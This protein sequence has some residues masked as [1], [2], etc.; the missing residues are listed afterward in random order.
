MG[1][2]PVGGQVVEADREVLG[3]VEIRQH[4]FDGG[5]PT[6]QEHVLR[7]RAARTGP[8]PDGRTLRHRDPPHHRHVGLGVEARIDLGVHPGH[9]LV[10]SRS[11]WRLRGWHHSRRAGHRTD[12]P[13]QPVHQLRRQVVDLA[14]QRRRPRVAA[15]HQPLLLFGESERAQREHLVHLGRVAEL[16]CALRSHLRVVVEDDRRRPGR[17]HAHLAIRPARGM[18]RSARTVRRNPWPTPGGSMS[19]MNAPPLIEITRWAATSATAQCVRP[20]GRIAAG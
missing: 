3:A 19:E 4:R 12:R 20:V 1:V 7:V 9:Q 16:R 6:V 18:P 13:V 10:G 8:Q 11:R 17:R 15:A 2:E 5:A 14:H